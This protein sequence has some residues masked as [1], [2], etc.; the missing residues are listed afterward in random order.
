ME[1]KILCNYVNYRIIML[2][3][4]GA[5][6]VCF[7]CMPLLLAV[8]YYHNAAQRQEEAIQTCIRFTV[9]A[10]MLSVGLEVVLILFCAFCFL[11]L[12]LNMLY[13]IFFEM[14]WEITAMGWR[15]PPPSS[16]SA[17]G[18]RSLVRG[19]GGDEGRFLGDGGDSDGDAEE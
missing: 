2:F 17:V 9:V 12:F 7:T 14:Y 3:L 1:T 13:L 8:C 19:R 5:V 11:A 18:L 10:M 4:F 15:S 16:L 6:S